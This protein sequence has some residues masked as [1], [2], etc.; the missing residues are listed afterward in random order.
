MTSSNAAGLYE[1]GRLAFIIPASPDVDPAP[2]IS[3]LM[4]EPFCFFTYEPCSA[5]D[6]MF[7]ICNIN[8]S[9]FTF[10]I[11]MLQQK[12]CSKMTNAAGHVQHIRDKIMYAG[13]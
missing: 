6:A 12:V 11:S 10:P 1:I 4:D 7:H 13:F 5:C 2:F 3:L 9:L 8:F